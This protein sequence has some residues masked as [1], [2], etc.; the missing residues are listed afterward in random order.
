MSRMDQMGPEGSAGSKLGIHE[1]G[2]VVHGVGVLGN[3]SQLDIVL[4]PLDL[5]IHQ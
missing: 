1:H 2:L 3:R 5:G 4:F